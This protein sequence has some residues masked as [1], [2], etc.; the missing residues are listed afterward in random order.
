M[1]KDGPYHDLKKYEKQEIKKNMKVNEKTLQKMKNWSQEKPDELKSQKRKK[2]RV[3]FLNLLIKKWILVYLEN[4]VY[5]IF[6]P[7]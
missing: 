2:P 3:V 4:I 1:T 7:K 5:H 6:Q